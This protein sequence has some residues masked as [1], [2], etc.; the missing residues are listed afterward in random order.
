[1][2]LLTERLKNAYV[3]LRDHGHNALQ[4]NGAGPGTR[5]WVALFAGAS[6]R[7]RHHRAGIHLYD[8]RDGGRLF[9]RDIWYE[10]DAWSMMNLTGSGEFA[11]HCGFVAPG[12]PNHLD[13]SLEWEKD[14][15]HSV[16]ALQFDGFAGKAAFTLVS[17][18]GGPIRVVAPS[19]DLKLYL[20]GYVTNNN[21]NLGGDAVAGRV[22]ASNVKLFRQDG[23]GLDAGDDVGAAA[24][25]FI[26]EMLAALRA[27]KPRPLT[28]LKAGVTDVRFYRVHANGKNGVRIQA[29]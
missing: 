27:V 24:P 7:H 25:S 9:V 14:L 17:S 28:D 15:R 22:V 20:L 16:A 1:Y 3:E 18:N 6:S 29:Q 23:T 8:V 19:P 2:G 26:R 4:V 12:D 11:Y 21:V 10:G 13:K 5:P